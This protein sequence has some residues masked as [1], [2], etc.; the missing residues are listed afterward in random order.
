MVRRIRSHCPRTR[1][2]G[3]SRPSV[4]VSSALAHWIRRGKDS[5]S[6]STNFKRPIASSW[7]PG[8][9]G[10]PTFKSF[11]GGRLAHSSPASARVPALQFQCNGDVERLEASAWSNCRDKTR[12]RRPISALF[13]ER[14][15]CR[16]CHRSWPCRL[17]RTK[18]C[19]RDAGFRKRSFG[20]GFRI[21]RC[22]W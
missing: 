13:T 22:R 5:S 7:C 6:C 18:G 9:T 8:S 11:T 14:R 15:T 20:D 21:A 1:L 10:S 4:R 3:V 17:P 2:R 16:S 12:D 19:P